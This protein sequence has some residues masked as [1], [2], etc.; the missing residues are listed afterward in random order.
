MI[1]FFKSMNF[2]SKLSLRAF[3]VFLI[4]ISLSQ[5]SQ[6]LE[7]DGQTF[8]R[9]TVKVEQ[10]KTSLFSMFVPRRQISLLRQRFNVVGINCRGDSD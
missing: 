3:L 4:T 9:L 6:A 7:I 5:A 2:F 8:C 1:V 10:P